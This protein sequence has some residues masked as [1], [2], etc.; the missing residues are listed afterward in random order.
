MKKGNLPTQEYDNGKEF[1]INLT[2]KKDF[3]VYKKGWSG[4]YTAAMA[5]DKLPLFSEF[6]K[7]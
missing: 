7:A 2:F 5:L 4:G 6:I 1:C 3:G